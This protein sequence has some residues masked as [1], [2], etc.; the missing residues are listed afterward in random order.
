MQNPNL[1]PT[2]KDAAEY[3]GVAP[4]TLSEWLM[5]GRYSVPH[6]RVGSRC[7][8]DKRDLDAWLAS[9]RRNAPTGRAARPS[10]VR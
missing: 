2:T 9:R 5:S 1:I 8:F 7:V 3:L 10:P 6:Y 4:R